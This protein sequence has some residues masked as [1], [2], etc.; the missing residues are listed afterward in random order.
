MKPPMTKLQISNQMIELLDT[1]PDYAALPSQQAEAYQL[2]IAIG[3]GPHSEQTIVEQLGLKS[4]LPWR[5]R[6]EHLQERGLIRV[7]APV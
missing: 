1:D 3:E 5:S 2:L 4:V 7:L 6:L